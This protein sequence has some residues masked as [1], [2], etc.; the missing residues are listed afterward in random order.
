MPSTPLND[1]MDNL[2]KIS[3]GDVETL[4]RANAEFSREITR[5]AKLPMERVVEMV[6]PKRF[7]VAERKLPPDQK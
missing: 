1:L 6:Q 3:Q 4:S 5:D 2:L 7:I